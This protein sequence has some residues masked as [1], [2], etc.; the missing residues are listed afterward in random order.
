VSGRENNGEGRGAV[1]VDGKIGKGLK[2]DG[3]RYVRIPN[4]NDLEKLQQGSYSISLWFKPAELPQ[5]Q[6]EEP[7]SQFGLVV[8][9]GYHEGLTFS[10]QGQF[11]M[12]HWLA[13]GP[14]AAVAVSGDTYEPGQ[15]HHV[16]GVVTANPQFKSPNAWPCKGVIDDVRMYH[17]ALSEAEVAKLFRAK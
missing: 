15:F 4:N 7:S 17:R 6:G 9:R 2:F 5:G 12:T 1:A 3:A 11:L 10:S 16:V 13:K 14:T 8:K